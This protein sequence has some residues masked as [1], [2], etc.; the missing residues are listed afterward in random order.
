MLAPLQLHLLQK[1]EAPFHI[2]SEKNH[3]HI[4]HH[5]LEKCVDSKTNKIVNIIT[6]LKAGNHYLPLLQTLLEPLHPWVPSPELL[7]LVGQPIILRY[8]FINIKWKRIVT[9]YNKME[10]VK[11]T[12]LGFFRKVELVWVVKTFKLCGMS[13]LSRNCTRHQHFFGLGIS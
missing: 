3:R 13:S 1:E 2:H 10:N 9:S 5:R 12:S 8:A 7:I 4:T 11:M 6:K